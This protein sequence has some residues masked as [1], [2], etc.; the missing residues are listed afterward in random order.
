MFLGCGRLSNFRGLSGPF[1][2]VYVSTNGGTTWTHTNLPYGP[3][4]AGQII[5][6]II[7]TGTSAGPSVITVTTSG[8]KRA[9]SSAIISGT[10][11]I[12]TSADLGVSW[13]SIST[14]NG[15]DVL[16]LDMIQDPLTPTKVYYVDNSK[17]ILKNTASGTGNWIAVADTTFMVNECADST[18]DGVAVDTVVNA[19]LAIHATATD[20][21]LYVG[22]YGSSTTNPSAVCYAFYFSKDEGQTWTTMFAPNARTL[23][24]AAGAGTS[25][26]PGYAA[27]GGQGST[28]FAIFADPIDSKYLYVGG[29]LLQIFRGDRTFIG[30]IYP[31]YLHYE[32]KIYIVLVMSYSL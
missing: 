10:G 30:R 6:K 2:G 24:T 20:N 28:N 15:A 16:P 25:P 18:T 7:I 21:I 27:L 9:K 31:F 13:T 5:N 19:K 17:R 26:N 11:A 8:Q 29:T 22:Y 12:Y 32:N 4:N 14:A 3:E 1:E 23:Y